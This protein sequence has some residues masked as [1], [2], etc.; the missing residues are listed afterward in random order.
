MLLKLLSMH[1]IL[2]AIMGISEAQPAEGQGATQCAT[3]NR[4]NFVYETPHIQALTREE[5]I[6]KLVAQK[7]AAVEHCDNLLHTKAGFDSSHCAKECVHTHKCEVKDIFENCAER[8]EKTFRDG[9][10]NAAA[11]FW[12]NCS[13]FSEISDLEKHP[14][15]SKPRRWECFLGL[16]IEGQDSCFPIAHPILEAE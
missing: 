15:F 12:K 11:P 9:V 13:V 16:S 10:E 1:I 14:F 7:E 4:V 2:A 6:L 3:D 8:W 5:S